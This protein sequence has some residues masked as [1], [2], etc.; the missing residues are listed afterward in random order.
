MATRVDD[1]IYNLLLIRKDEK[2]IATAV[3]EQVRTLTFDEYNGYFG[4]YQALVRILNASVYSFV[5]ES[6]KMLGKT[7]AEVADEM[8]RGAISNVNP[9]DGMAASVRLRY[10]VL[11]FCSSIYSHQEQSLVLVKRKFGH[12]SVQAEAINQVFH[13]IY[14][15]CFAY[16]YLMKLR[17]AMI[18][19]TAEAASVHMSS[20]LVEGRPSGTA[21]AWLDRT[22]LLDPGNRLSAALRRELRGLPGDP[23]ILQ[24]IGELMPEMND[25]NSKVVRIIHPELNKFKSTIV[26]LESRFGGRLGARAFGS[27]DTRSEFRSLSERNF[28]YQVIAPNILVFAHTI[29]AP[30]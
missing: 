1:K 25:L 23:S 20:R 5:I 29:D 16:R 2:A 17:H 7:F 12:T 30:S 6:A 4:A 13:D 26:E 24:M 8:A 3:F 14:D 11:A 21:D 9:E 15:G 18:H 19:L 22:V 27:I 28:S 10:A